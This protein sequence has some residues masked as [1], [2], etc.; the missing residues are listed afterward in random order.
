MMLS[1]AKAENAT[2]TAN[3][4]AMIRAFAKADATL[5]GGFVC[6]MTGC[7][8]AAADASVTVSVVEPTVPV[9]VK[10]IGLAEHVAPVGRPVQ[11][12]VLMLPLKLPTAD[13]SIVTEPVVPPDE[14]VTDD[15]PL[16]SEKLGVPMAVARLAK[17]TVPRPVE[18]S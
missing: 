13:A 16:E 14:I 1:R 18:R 5:D 10:L 11:V 15:A 7:T 9:P 12:N 3:T 17:F 8:C 4:G 2:S 6:G